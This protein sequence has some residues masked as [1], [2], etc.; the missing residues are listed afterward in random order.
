MMKISW[1]TGIVI[2]ILIFMIITTVG[3]IIFMK[4][5]VD[6]VTDN[7]YEKTLVYQDQI[8]IQKRTVELNDEVSLK[9][10]NS[11][12]NI[13]FPKSYSEDV[14]D[15]KLFFYRPSD[16]KKDFNVPLQLDAEGN[17]VLSTSKI[18]KG[19]WKIGISWN[20]NEQE[21]QTQKS[22]IIY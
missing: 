17:Q 4:Q 7:Y 5:D 19:F 14:N 10:E 8:D 18:I 11:L 2:S 9:F 1:G 21:Y 15:G 12:L 20:M 13:S 22:I 3:M 6:L 16:S